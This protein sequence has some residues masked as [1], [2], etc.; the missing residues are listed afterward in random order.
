MK[1]RP[2]LLLQSDPNVIDISKKAGLGDEEVKWVWAEAED[3]ESATHAEDHH[4]SRWSGLVRLRAHQ[5]AQDNQ[6]PRLS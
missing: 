4:I 3:E 1:R 6:G 2:V 5:E